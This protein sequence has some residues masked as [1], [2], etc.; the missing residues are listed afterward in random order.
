MKRIGK[1]CAVGLIVLLMLSLVSISLSALAQQELEKNK[2]LV[3]RTIEMWNTGDVSIADEVC[4]DVIV[5]HDLAF[6]SGSETE[7]I[8]EFKQGVINSLTAF[9]D[10]H[11]T[12][13]DLIAEGD[14][15][16]KLWASSG[17]HKGEFGG[18]PATGKKTE[19][20]YCISLYRIENGKIAEIWMGYSAYKLLQ[21]I[22]VIP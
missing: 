19:L 12:L 14:K 15:V 18:I 7:T 17:T 1:T 5:Q 16:T 22:G 6:L 11:I 2:E 3:R 10:F 13:I 8:E 4:A 21:Q 20:E 9:P